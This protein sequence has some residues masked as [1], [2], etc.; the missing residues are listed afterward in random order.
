MSLQ[1]TIVVYCSVYTN[2]SSIQWL[3]MEDV[4]NNID[5]TVTLVAFCV[6]V[7]VNDIKHGE[8]RQRLQSFLA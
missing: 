6:I 7:F 8:R 2:Y 3:F 1:E 5:N 4:R